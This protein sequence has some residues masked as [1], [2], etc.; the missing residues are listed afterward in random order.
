MKYART[1]PELAE[2]MGVHLS[3]LYAH[4]LSKPGFPAKTA[5]GWPLEACDQFRKKALE[6]ARKQLRGPDQELKKQ[7]LEREITILDIKIAEL[8]REL[9]PM[10]E[11]L[12]ELQQFAHI[13]CSVLEHDLEE[14]AAL[15]KDPAIYKRFQER[16]NG[17]RQRMREGIEAQQ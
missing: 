15:I 17:V 9:I 13:A 12:A 2:H 16:R 1:K 7:K 5:R 3:A 10:S 14:V 8:R 11:H 4:W 6:S